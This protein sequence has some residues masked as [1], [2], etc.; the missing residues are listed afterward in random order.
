[1]A[2]ITSAN[3]V[4]VLGVANLYNTPVQIEGFS[5]DDAF[6]ME[7]VES[8]ETQMGVDGNLSAGYT[9][10]ELP[11]EITLQSDSASNSIFEAIIQAEA[12]SRDKY[13]INGSL[14]YPSIGY[15]YSFVTGYLKKFTPIPP[16][17]KVLQPRKYE[18]V[19]QNATRAP[20]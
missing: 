1:M 3:A 10:Y 13:E 9:P 12:I 6:T 17:K 15:L 8:A 19:F 4:L 18:I 2:T 16:G 14:R 11:L 7:D 5:V 20:I